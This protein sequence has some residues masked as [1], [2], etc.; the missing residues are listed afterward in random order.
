VRNL[1]T[2]LASRL[3]VPAD[4][5]LLELLNQETSPFLRNSLFWALAQG[6][7][8]N[9][10]SKY[11]SEL[12]SDEQLASYNR[13]YTLYY[14]GDLAASAGP[15]H[16]DDEPDRTWSRTREALNQRYNASSYASTALARKA[17]DMYTFCDIARVR[18]Q[19]LTAEEQDRFRRLISSLKALQT[20]QDVVAVLTNQLDEGSAP[21]L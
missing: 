4:E 1:L 7:N 3:E 14:Y 8:W 10:T 15:P 20:P 6:G 12:K 13:G 16:S 18:D 2:Y 21:D 11:L 19:L 5:P 9:T 17:I